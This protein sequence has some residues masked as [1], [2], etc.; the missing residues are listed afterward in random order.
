MLKV[1]AQAGAVPC[2]VVNGIPE[3]LLISTRSGKHMTIPK[4]LIDP[5]FSAVETAH[6]EAM[7][8][9]GIK[10]RLLVPEIGSYRFTKWGG[11]CEVSV[12]VMMV[13]E[14]MDQWPEA[15]MRRRTWMTY[16][17]AAQ[18]V[19]Y[20]DLGRLILKVSEVIGER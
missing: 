7:E 4:G 1:F 3:I 18:R 6:C 2:R 8:E 12:F 19:K 10:G 5:G 13:G 15:A 9:A 14:T 11:I 20:P 16:D 17:K